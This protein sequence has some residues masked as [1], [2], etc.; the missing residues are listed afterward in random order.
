MSNSAKVDQKGRLKIPVTLLPMLKGAG[1]EFYVTSEDGYSVR[2]YP[3]QVWNQVEEQL[4]RLSSHNRNN[5][6]LLV[7]AKYFG[8]AVTMDKQGRLLIP[9]V[10][11]G[12]AQMTC[13]VDILDYPNYLEVWNH[14]QFLKHL[15]SSPITAQDE[16]T[17]NKLSHGTERRFR[18]HRRVRPDS[19]GQGSHVI[20]G[21][22][23]DS[24]GRARVA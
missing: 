4:D 9:I 13:A 12:S 7:R 16:N 3:M 21:V 18:V 2:I 19:R 23:T 10:L 11:R 1:T 24:A 20:R 17:L 14:A 6:K 5:Q 8:R 15:E 22:R